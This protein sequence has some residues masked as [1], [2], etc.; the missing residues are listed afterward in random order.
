MDVGTQKLCFV[1][2]APKSHLAVSNDQPKFTYFMWAKTDK[3]KR[4]KFVL[5]LMPPK[6]IW[7]CPHCPVTK[8]VLFVGQIYLKLKKQTS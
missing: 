8:C 4:G 1:P 3:N 5:S 6:V 2:N 7:G